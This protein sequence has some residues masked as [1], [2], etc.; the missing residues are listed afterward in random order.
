MRTAGGY[1]T[2]L[3]YSPLAALPPESSFYMGKACQNY[4]TVWQVTDL[5]KK[6][7]AL[8]I[9][10]VLLA[11]ALGATARAECGDYV[12]RD[13]A[14]PMTA[15]DKSHGQSGTPLANDMPHKRCHGPHCSQGTPPKPVPIG[16]IVPTSEQWGCIT[17][18]AVVADAPANYRLGQDC[19]KDSP[20]FVQAIYHPPRLLP[21]RLS[22]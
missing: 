12:G 14:A 11:S 1:C 21:L 13:T 8:L 9:A 16:V 2:L 10:G 22:C 18:P 6:T 15:V 5:L 20:L 17:L 3:Y 19:P 7:F 4:A